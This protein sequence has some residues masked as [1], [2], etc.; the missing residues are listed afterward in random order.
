MH[1]WTAM[2]PVLD[3]DKLRVCPGQQ[4]ATQRWLTQPSM[5]LYRNEA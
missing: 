2:V 1:H 4:E 5:P 3:P